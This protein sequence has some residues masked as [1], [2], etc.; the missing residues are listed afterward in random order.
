MKYVIIISI[1]AFL[2]CLI[3]IYLDN[4]KSIFKKKQKPVKQVKTEKKE[5]QDFEKFV[6]SQGYEMSEERDSSLKELLNT[7]DIKEE[8]FFEN[9]EPEEVYTNQQPKENNNK[10]IKEKIDELSPDLK[11]L[12]I[13]GLL[14]KKIE[15]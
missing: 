13:D 9:F 2:C 4:I 1:I 7:K 8:D 5:S 15:D 10:T 14:T 12:L 11:I 6:V 3:Y